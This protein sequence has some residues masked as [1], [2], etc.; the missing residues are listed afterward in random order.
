MNLILKEKVQK[1]GDRA[2]YVSSVE[3]GRTQ[4]SL[5]AEQFAPSV[6]GAVPVGSGLPVAVY[7]GKIS[8]W[9]FLC[10]RNDSNS[11]YGYEFSLNYVSFQA[12]KLMDGASANSWNSE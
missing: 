2:R 11:S 8:A 1:F 7:D 5:N 12:L 4:A 6:L 9:G 10:G 3:P